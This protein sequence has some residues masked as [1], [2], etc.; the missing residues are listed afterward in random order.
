M[1]TIVSGLPRSGTS[2]LMQML[3]AGG[4]PAY[5][6]GLRE[7]DDSN[8]RG[9]FE[10]KDVERMSAE[11]YVDWLS[12]AEGKAVKVIS[13]HLKALPLSGYEYRVLLLHRNIHEVLHS[14]RQMLLRRGHPV[15]E[16]SDAEVM[17]ASCQHEWDVFLYLRHHSCFRVLEVEHANLVKRNHGKKLLCSAVKEISA[18]LGGRLRRG[19][20]YL[21]VDR[22]LYQSRR[23]RIN[24]IPDEPQ[25]GVFVEK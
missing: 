17:W 5:A 22:E 3:I 18:F 4:I 15:L 25:A 13:T 9:Y 24:A 14:Q 11:G 23:E 16:S 20:M 7:P 2:L 10:H 1:I 6:D 8:P 12:E 21:V 19:P